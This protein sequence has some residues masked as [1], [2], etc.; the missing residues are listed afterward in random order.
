[1]L[2]CG[3]GLFTKTC[4]KRREDELIPFEIGTETMTIDRALRLD[5]V[6]EI[7]EAAGV[8]PRRKPKN[9]PSVKLRLDKPELAQE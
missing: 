6:G 5:R 2:G 8:M 7:E 4:T 9:W 1:M 3:S